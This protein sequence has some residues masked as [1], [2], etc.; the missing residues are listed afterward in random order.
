MIATGSIC[1]NLSKIASMP[2]SGEQ[3]LQIAPIE[4]TAK[5]LIIVLG[6]FAAIA[7]IRSFFLIP[8]DFK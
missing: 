2:K 6:V 5:K 4:F 1:E 3:L 7:T 8:I